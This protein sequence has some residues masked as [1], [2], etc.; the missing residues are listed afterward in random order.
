VEV[1]FLLYLSAI[2]LLL[3]TTQGRHGSENLD[4]TVRELLAPGF[5]VEAEKPALL[6]R[7]IPAGVTPDSNTASALEQDSTNIIT[8]YGTVADLRFDIV[9]IEDT[10]SGRTLP[11]EAASLTRIGERSAVFRWQPASGETL[12]NHV[13]RVTV[14]ATGRPIPPPMLRPETRRIVDQILKRGG[15]IAD[16]VTFTVNL[17]SVD[18]RGN[19]F[20]EVPTLR[21]PEDEKRPTTR[22]T[23]RIV[24]PAPPQPVPMPGLRASNLAVPP[25]KPWT[26]AIDL[27]AP[28]GGAIDWAIDAPASVR[29][30]A[31]S[32]M[33]IRLSGEGPPSGTMQNITV[34]AKRRADGVTA[35]ATFTVSGASTG[36]ASIPGEMYVG[37]QYT[38]R[39]GGSAE[40]RVELRV[41]QNGQ[42]IEKFLNRPVVSFTPTS[43]GN[44]EFVQSI[45][46]SEQ[47]FTATVH[48]S[49]AP[50]VQIVEARGDDEVILQSISYGML[51]GRT[52]YSALHIADGNANDPVL[53]DETQNN[54]EPTVR[55]IQRWR[56]TPKQPGA[57][58]VFRAYAIDQSGSQRGK[59]AIVRYP[60]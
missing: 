55:F 42:Q 53:I 57:P 3:G 30:I 43:A 49:R 47:R 23:V 28:P 46:G 44:L 40:D 59:S 18:N 1:Y 5:R 4:D 10:I 41:M 36:S 22:D 34:T 26:N 35:F 15:T 12:E 19:V 14:S 21:T 54:D 13:Y 37:Q 38:L 39:L 25:G 20:A 32:Q 58:F 52:N 6:W 31:S 8:A 24:E 56:V 33:G 11:A 27:S 2:I 16:S 29:M 7:F 17:L 60:R 48:A 9:E 50:V 45:N 51:K